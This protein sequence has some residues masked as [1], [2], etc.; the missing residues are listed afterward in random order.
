MGVVPPRFA[1]EIDRRVARIVG[2]RRRAFI[3]APET[4]EA[5]PRFQQRP[6]DR[7]VLVREQAGRRAPAP[8]TASKNAAAMSPSSSRSRFLLKV[9]GDQIGSSIP[10]PTNQRNSTL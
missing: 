9:V 7:E 1:V 5:R 2:R 3:L 8:T 10:S 6:V 4:L